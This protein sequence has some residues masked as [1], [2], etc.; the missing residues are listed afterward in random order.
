MTSKL[1]FTGNWV[2][3]RQKPLTW[4]SCQKPI[5]INEL[6][7]RLVQNNTVCMKENLRKT[8]LNSPN[9]PYTPLFEF[10]RLKLTN[11]PKPNMHI[12]LI[13]FRLTRSSLLNHLVFGSEAP[14]HSHKAMRATCFQLFAK[15]SICCIRIF[16]VRTGYSDASRKV[17]QFGV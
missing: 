17:A 9:H 1:V 12:I 2:W 15:R 7:N 5:C 8:Y 6:F 14:R 11:V 3:A 10:K 4:F 13:V 16:K